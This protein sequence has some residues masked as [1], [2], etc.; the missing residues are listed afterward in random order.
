MFQEYFD[1]PKKLFTRLEFDVQPVVVVTG[2]REKDA[3]E[4]ADLPAEME[5]VGAGLVK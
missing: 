4:W 5:K 2:M 1:Y 3:K